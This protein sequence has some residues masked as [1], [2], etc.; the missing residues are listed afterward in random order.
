M[1]R[2]SPTLRNRVDET[3]DAMAV[4]AEP[5]AMLD[6]IKESQTSRHANIAGLGSKVES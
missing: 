1:R 3:A 6:A 5:H 2:D 4:A